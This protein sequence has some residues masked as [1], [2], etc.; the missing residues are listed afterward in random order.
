MPRMITLQVYIADD[1]WTCEETQRIVAD[2]APKFPKV[3]IEVLNTAVTPMPEN[4][5]AVPT[6]V[7]DGRILYLGNPTRDE[8]YNRL[9][10]HQE[11]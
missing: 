8:L 1:C 5:F 3:M 7:L 2:I 11:M 9:L 6:Y 4:V 10:V